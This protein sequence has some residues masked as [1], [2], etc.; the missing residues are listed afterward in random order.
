MRKHQAAMPPRAHRHHAA[1]SVAC[2]FAIC[3]GASG[4]DRPSVP[5]AEV[6]NIY[7]GGR[8]DDLRFRVWSMTQETRDGRI[9]LNVDNQAKPWA[10]IIFEPAEKDKPILV[11]TEDWISK[12]FARFSIDALPDQYGNTTPPC[13]F[14]FRLLGCTKRYGGIND[15]W[16]EGG[17]GIDSDP[18]TWQ[19]VRVPI[20]RFEVKPGDRVTGIGLQCRLKPKSPF[21]VADFA[22]V[23][24][25]RIE[26]VSAETFAQPWVTWPEYDDLPDA[27][28]ADRH[29][30]LYRNGAFVT[31]DG[32]R[33]FLTM[34]Y[35]REDQRSGLDFNRD[36]KLPPHYDLYD[37][38]TQGF[39]YEQPLDGHSLS[40][41]GFNSLSVTMYPRLFWD[42]VGYQTKRRLSP[43]DQASFEKLVR[44]VRLPFFVDMVCWPWTLGGPGTDKATNL[45]PSALHNGRHH[46]TPYRI[47][48]KGRDV[49]LT[50]W[51]TYA[52]RYGQAGANVIFYELMN[53]PAYMATT[54]D[55][56]A[57]FVEWLKRRYGALG[58]VNQTW[59]ASYASWDKVRDFKK[60]DENAGLFLDYD[61]YLGDT[62]AALVADGCK[63][64]EEITPGV[65]AGIQTMGGY[66]LQP[67]DA[68][69]PS[70]FIPLQRAVLTPTGGGRWTRPIG[71]A[72]PRENT[73]DYG[74]SASPLANDL[75]LTMSGS[76]MIVDNEMY[77]GPG[78]TRD[79]LRNRWWKA[80]IVGLD[81][82]TWFSWS[83][84]GWAW[85]RGLDNIVREGER[86]PYSGLIP[87]ARRADAIRGTLEFAREIE[88]VRDYVLPKPWG[89]RPKVAMLY[90]W[91]S[92]RWR[93]WERQLRDKSGDYHAAMRHLHWHF[94]TLPS[95]MALSDALSRYDLVVAGG[96]DHIEPQLLSRLT[97]FVKKGGTLIVGDGAMDR[98]PYGNKLDS[99]PLL[100]VNVVRQVRS[101]A[102]TL[103]S[104][105]LPDFDL[106][107]GAVV[108]SAGFAEVRP[109]RSAKALVTDSSGR[110]MVTE[111][112]LG[113]GSVYFIAPDLNGYRLAKMLASI[114]KRTGPQV[115]TLITDAHTAQLAPNVLLSRRSYDSH[116]ALLMLNGDPFPKLVNARM[117]DVTGDWHVCD[118]LRGHEIRRGSGASKWPAASLAGEGITYCIDGGSPGLILLTRERW[119]RSRLAATDSRATEE[120]YRAAR[121]SWQ[122]SRGETAGAFQ[123][124]PSRVA[125]VDLRALANTTPR[126]VIKDAKERWVGFPSTEPLVRTFAGVPF[127]IIR[128]DHNEMKGFIALRSQT[129]P[130]HPLTVRGA[131][132]NA[133]ARRVFF[134]HTVGEGSKGDT[135]GKYVVNYA[136]GTSAEIPITVGKTAARLADRRST[137]AALCAGLV[138]ATGSAWHVFEWP[139]PRPAVRV[140]SVDLTAA[141]TASG[142]L[143]LI[144]VTFE[145]AE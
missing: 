1:L 42:A 86:F 11:L 100:G 105:G 39:I 14:Q 138:T 32:R 83:K 16:Y 19:T 29:P 34:P 145:R 12:G 78:Q 117:L 70:K 61:E 80:V 22:F 111:H 50:M 48:G 114:R 129:T 135:L 116:H 123:V 94:D 142:T 110:P 8:K 47:I 118:P 26:T 63:A 130:E 59:R 112:R 120:R 141:P 131:R 71:N 101:P 115:K 13:R 28:K 97:R 40:R 85:W 49:W 64:I 55:H 134:L 43:F 5:P 2:V 103:K 87:P 73:I 10:G 82:A 81:G 33:S 60:R 119:N 37:R 6:L 93:T 7:S 90:S 125:Y 84:R 74:M 67:R 56:R 72:Q 9:V 133:R 20:K 44:T 98:D 53:E 41:L 102:G 128:L 58:R 109:L 91:A 144:G 132:I 96:I 65:P 25:D 136:D 15:S 88:L 69:Y 3:L 24:Y 31:P 75:L 89:P 137:D 106:L 36:G 126:D 46:W 38:K 18:E 79:A 30:P 127:E 35:A 66:V 77:L 140:Q 104:A 143:V 107:P 23:R 68:I 76:K 57:E 4:A 124:D 52:R 17:K 92:A 122:K 139:N 54:P 45:P 27:L 113:D 62:F 21:A 51:T 108:A 95:H 99:T 121:S